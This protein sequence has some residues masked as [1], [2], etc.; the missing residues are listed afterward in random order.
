MGMTVRAVLLL[1]G[2][3]LLV[4]CGDRMVDSPAALPPVT[5]SPAPT[6]V[7]L[8]A[9]AA[10]GVCHQGTWTGIPTDSF[11]ELADGGD[12]SAGALHGAVITR[13]PNLVY[14]PLSDAETTWCGNGYE[15]SRNYFNVI[16]AGIELELPSF[17]VVDASLLAKAKARK[18]LSE[19]EFDL[20]N[21]ELEAMSKAPGFDWDWSRACRSTF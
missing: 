8:A 4:A 17:S 14:G 10:A 13:C 1:S 9:E 20:L 18:Q 6:L 21:A 12:Y 15:I 11:E 7:D 3:L 19:Y 2:V 16:E 5:P